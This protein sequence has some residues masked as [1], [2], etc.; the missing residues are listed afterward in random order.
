[1][2]AANSTHPTYQVM[3]TQAILALKDRTGSSNIAIQKYLEANFRLPDNYKTHLR[4]QLRRLVEKG[5]LVKVKASYKLSPEAKVVAQKAAKKAAPAKKTTS[6]KKTTTKKAPAKKTATK[7]KP[8]AKKAA[9]KKT[10]KKTTK[11]PAAK[12]ATKKTAKKGAKKTTKRGK[13]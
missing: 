10:T 11:K 1:M 9:A 2:P 3:V 5:T 12:K 7:K 13:K 4:T 8:A 6:T